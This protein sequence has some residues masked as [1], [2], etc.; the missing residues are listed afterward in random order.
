MNKI[1][2]IKFTPFTY[3]YAFDRGQSS[4]INNIFFYQ[5]SITAFQY[6]VPHKMNMK[7]NNM[8]VLAKFWS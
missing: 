4:Y 8:F 7:E 6:I 1:S 2:L 3:Y 5:T